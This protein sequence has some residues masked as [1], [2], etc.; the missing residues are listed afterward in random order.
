MLNCQDIRNEGNLA[1]DAPLIPIPMNCRLSS[2]C[3]VTFNASTFYTF[4]AIAIKISVAR[5]KRR[6]RFVLRCAGQRALNYEGGIQ[7]ECITREGERHEQDSSTCG[8]LPSSSFFVFFDPRRE[9]LLSSPH[10]LFCD[11]L[12]SS[13]S[14]R[15][16]CLHSNQPLAWA[17][18]AAHERRITPFVAGLLS[19]YSFSRVAPLAPNYSGILASALFNGLF[20]RLNRRIDFPLGHFFCAIFQ[21]AFNY[22]WLA[23]WCV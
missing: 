2:R 1:A 8:R 5:E 23:R 21:P 15:R 11:V 14:T 22:S 18:Q 9:T 20:Y 3:G 4:K 17:S 6:R 19:L 10:R 7:S 16:T 12:L 13:I